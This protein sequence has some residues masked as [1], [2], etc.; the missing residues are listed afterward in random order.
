MTK[1]LTVQLLDFHFPLWF[2]STTTKNIQDNWW[3]L[4]CSVTAKDHWTSYRRFT[5]VVCL[6]FLVE[7]RERIILGCT[8]YAFSLHITIL[9][10]FNRNS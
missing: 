5:D 10:T 4:T 6:D 7:S 1:Y 2:G 8:I 3:V 9:C